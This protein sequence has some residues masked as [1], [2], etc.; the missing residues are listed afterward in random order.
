MFGSMTT[1]SPSLVA[2]TPGPTDSMVPNAS[3]PM[4]QG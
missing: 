3:W 4:I 1:V 2:G